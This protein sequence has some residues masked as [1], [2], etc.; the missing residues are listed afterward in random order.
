MEFLYFLF[1]FTIKFNSEKS[2]VFGLGLIS[3]VDTTSF[4]V[5]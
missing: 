3:E 4:Y 1:L 2:E 5:G